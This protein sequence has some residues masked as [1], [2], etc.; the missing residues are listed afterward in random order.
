MIRIYQKPHKLMC[1]RSIKPSSGF[2]L[3]ELLCVIAVVAILA[4]LV[5]AAVGRISDKAKTVQCVSHL[6]QLGAAVFLYVAE[7]D[8]YIMPALD[9]RPEKNYNNGRTWHSA[10][11]S[12][13]YFDMDYG[14]NKNANIWNI[15][16]C[17]SAFPYKHKN[18]PPNYGLMGNIGACYGMRSWIIPN[19]ADGSQWFRPRKLISIEKPS[20]FFLI[21]DSW[22]NTVQGQGYMIEPMPGNGNQFVHLRHGGGVANC[23]MADGSVQAKNAEWFKEIAESQLPYHRKPGGYLL[24]AD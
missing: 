1:Q 5:L 23:L 9:M 7:N 19:T 4:I 11:I 8:G 21:A 2:T 20:E 24:K 3:I 13:G 17:P 18:V 22:W 16:Y 12:G 10:L 15:F 6:K 14:Q